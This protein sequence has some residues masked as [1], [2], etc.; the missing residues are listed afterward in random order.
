MDEV[1]GS[2]PGEVWREVPGWEGLYF[3]SSL[4][5][6]WSKPRFKVRGGFRQLHV[7]KRTGYIS[8]GLG[9]YYSKSYAVHQLVTLAFLGPCP[10]GQEVRHLD[11][12]RQ[13]ARLDNLAY[14]THAENMTDR[15]RHGTD[16][17]ANKTHC[18]RGHP[19]SDLNTFVYKGRRSCRTCTRTTTKRWGHQ[20][21]RI[22]PGDFRCKCGVPLA[23]SERAAREVMATHREELQATAVES[24]GLPAQ[25]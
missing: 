24:A 14:S 3:V 25:T 6:V 2:L 1:I 7:N 12:N 17:Q 23:T 16:P 8:V 22:G 4:G 18:P 19:Y 20:P 13:N 5:R 9:G 21:V 11:G 10:P 15:R